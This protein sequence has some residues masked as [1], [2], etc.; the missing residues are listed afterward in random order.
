MPP[1]PQHITRAL[2]ATY[3]FAITAEI[4]LALAFNQTM[5]GGMGALVMSATHLE[6]LRQWPTVTIAGIS[7]YSFFMR[8]DPMLLGWRPVSWLPEYYT[9]GALAGMLQLTQQFQRQ[10]YR[11]VN[12]QTPGTPF[13]RPDSPSFHR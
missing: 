2:I 13:D 6:R 8:D 12:R 1:N 7:A 5:A 11:L 3:G 4:I 9:I 10:T